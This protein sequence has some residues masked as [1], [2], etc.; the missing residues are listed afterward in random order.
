MANLQKLQSSR[1]SIVVASDTVNIPSISSQ[2]GKGN[3]GCTLYVGTGGNLRVL[4]VGG[5][6][7]IFTALQTGSFLPVNVLRVFNTNTT[8]ADILALW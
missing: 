8:A 4:T 2:D 3:N 6:D 5:D 7:V 1:A